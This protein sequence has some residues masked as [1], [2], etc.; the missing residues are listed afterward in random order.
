MLPWQIQSRARP[1]IRRLRRQF[2]TLLGASA[3]SAIAGLVAL[4]VN[5]R[6]LGAEQFGAL[7]L[8]LAYTALFGAISTFDTWQPV[9]RLG[10]RAPRSLGLILSAGILLDVTAALAAT[11]M[12]ILV[13]MAF[14][15]WTGIPVEVLW[16][17]QLHALSLL[18]GVAGTPKGYFRLTERFDILAGNQIWLALALA[19]ASLVLWLAAA[20]LATYVVVFAL[21]SATF[22]LTLML[23][24]VLTLRSKGLRLTFP[25]ASPA[26]RRVLRML[27]RTATGTSLLS[28]LTSNRR[29]LALLLI[30]NLLGETAAGLLA[31]AAQLA[32]AVSRFGNLAMQVLFKSVLQAAHQHAP[33]L[34][35]S[36]VLKATAISALAAAALALAAIPASALAIPILLGASFAASVPIFAGLF[37]AECA[38]LA[39]LHLNPVIQQKA[40]PR[41]L[42]GIAAAGMGLHLAAI[43]VLAPLWGAMGAGMAS[44]M[45]SLLVAAM[46]LVTADRLLRRAISRADV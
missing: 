10:V 33:S 34:W 32:S 11:F 16:L 5:V 21:V 14:G 24:M 9:V 40:G 31:A 30:S 19:L 42:V 20:E 7:S 39:V 26:G 15:P 28:T 36:K 46:M 22:N 25:F 17:A 3:V 6:G 38:N 45:G 8:I 27:F 37:A 41:P 35:R 18:G 29:H 43:F 1:P 4:T 23:R 13:S 12:A 44:L 2:A